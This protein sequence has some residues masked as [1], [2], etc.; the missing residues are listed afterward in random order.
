[1]MLAPKSGY[2]KVLCIE[3]LSFKDVVWG[4]CS[5]YKGEWYD[6]IEDG[7]FFLIKFG[8]GVCPHSS[9]LFI[10]Q[11]QIRDNRLSNLIK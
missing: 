9:H 4:D 6:G 10:T 3:S 11:C 7:G 1:M 5:V 8:T 2:I